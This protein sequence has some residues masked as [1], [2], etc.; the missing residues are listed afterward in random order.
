LREQHAVLYRP[1]GTKFS[2]L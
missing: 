2:E 1:S